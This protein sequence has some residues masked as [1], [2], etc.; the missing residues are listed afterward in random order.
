ML[1]QNDNNLNMNNVLP[2]S[3]HLHFTN[4]T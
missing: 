4:N 1:E 3:D 2:G